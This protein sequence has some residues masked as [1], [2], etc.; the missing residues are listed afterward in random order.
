MK[1]SYIAIEGPMKTGKF[2]LANILA[3]E[4][5]GGVIH[6]IVDNPF[7]K[8]FY[9]GKENVA[10]LTQLVFLINRYNQLT[11]LFQ[12]RLFER[13]IVCDYIFE[14]DKIYAYQ[15]LSDNELEI[16]NKIFDIFC[17][18]VPKP[19][20]VIYLQISDE[21][22]IK[23]IR[24]SRNQ[25]ERYI[26][27]QYLRDINEAFN[28]FFFHYTI[29]PLLIINTDEINIDEDKN[30]DIQGIKSAIEEIKGGVKIYV[31]K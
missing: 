28:Y 18:R 21:N 5:D 23:R 3:N 8:E 30:L 10:L 24:K 11:E 4:F 13:T 27:E 15:I 7:L 14:K 12:Q 9:K 22:L 20:L 25:Y 17:K 2:K 26:S 19:D 6:D 31:P 29:S 1:F 16:Y